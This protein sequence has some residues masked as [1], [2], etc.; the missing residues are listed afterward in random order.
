MATS[1]K[2]RIQQLACC[3]RK[4]AHPAIRGWPP[5]PPILVRTIR[6]TEGSHPSSGWQ[7]HRQSRTSSV[8]SR[9]G[10][11]A[12][13][14]PNLLVADRVLVPKPTKKRR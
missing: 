7:I 12:L 4:N 2:Q 10:G 14:P 13:Q 5:G 3:P 11:G 8:E 6:A 9:G 1:S